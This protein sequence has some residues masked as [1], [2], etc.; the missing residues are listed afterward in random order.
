[1]M[2]DWVR[3]LRPPGIRT[4]LTLLYTAVFALVI[5]LFGFA[6]YTGLRGSLAGTFD[7][8]LQVRTQAIAAGVSFD[9]GTICVQDVTVGLPDLRTGACGTGGT[10]SNA[11]D[12]GPGGAGQSGPQSNVDVSTLVRILNTKGQTVY[13]SPAFRLISAPTVSV[14]QPLSGSTWS[15]TVSTANGH[16]VRLYSAPLT[17]NNGAVYGVVQ[18]AESLAPLDATLHTILLALF[19]ITPFALLLSALGSYVLAARAFRPVRL[20]TR[21]ARTIEAGDLHQRVPVP[22]PSD[23]IRDLA[24]TLNAMIARLDAAFTQQRRFVADASHELRTPVAVIR[25]VSDVALE[26]GTT[27]EEYGVAL[28]DIGAEAERLGNLI[29]E[30]LLLARADEGHVRLDSEP[31]R[32]DLLAADVVA[33]MESLAAERDVMLRTD[34]LEAATVVGD[35]ARLIQVILNLVD[36][37]IHYTNAGGAV[38]LSVEVGGSQARLAVRDTGIGIAAEDLTPIFERFYR[39]D[40]ARSRVAGG[41]GLGLSIAEWVV[42]AHG[43]S[44]GVTST[45]GQGSTFTVTLPLAK[46]G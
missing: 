2:P 37:A 7:N 35:A 34:R 17:D 22:A 4:Q 13:V 41:S 32:L 18:V 9:N 20:L 3:H 39:A 29:N 24:L 6:F 11:S 36:N 5:A 46:S 26:Q 10:D 28:R 14:R 12:S 45:M 43:G 42:R 1:M 40:P 27:Q 33:S 8:A 30:L 23:E 15:G 38:T 21:T 31:V 19:V 25:S 16:T 44:I